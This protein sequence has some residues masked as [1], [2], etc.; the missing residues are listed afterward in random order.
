MRRLFFSYNGVNAFVIR[1]KSFRNFSTIPHG[2]TQGI[3]MMT[4]NFI[5]SFKKL[6]YNKLAQK[7]QY[8]KDGYIL[9][10]NCLSQEELDRY[11][12]NTKC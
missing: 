12:Y 5:F 9:I 6:I 10:K 1:S 8:E 7:E 3:Y 2:L 11:V 4:Y